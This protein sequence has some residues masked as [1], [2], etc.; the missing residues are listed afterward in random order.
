MKKKVE[1]LIEMQKYDDRIAEKETLKSELPKQLKSLIEAEA[2]AKTAV[3]ETIEDINKLVILQ[4]DKEIEIK[5]NKEKA[6]KYEEQL[7]SI[8]TN[9]EYKALNSEIALLASLNSEL[10]SEI[11]SLMEQENQLKQIKV[12][13]EKVLQE[14]QKNLSDQ[15]DV[16]KDQIAGL[17]GEIEKFKK[18]RN[19]LAIDLPKNMIKQYKILIINRNRKAV[20]FEQEGACSACGFKIRPQLIIELEKQDKILFCE[21]C[22][23]FL[24]R[25]P[26]H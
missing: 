4:K 24:V 17:D 9:K 20:A 23:R 15:E 8:K 22:N 25:K 26:I 10:E 16:L 12:E 19:S 18:E 14:K 1:C 5:Q 7:A 21:N 13:R 2:E 11:I 6:A 3:A